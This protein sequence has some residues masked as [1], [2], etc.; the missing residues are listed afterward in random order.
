LIGDRVAGETDLKC[1]VETARGVRG[2]VS[3]SRKDGISMRRAGSLF[4]AA[5]GWISGI[6]AFQCHAQAAPR[7]TSPY[8]AN[9]APCHGT[10]LN[11]GP[12][13]PALKGEPFGSRWGSRPRT[14]LLEFMSTKMPPS[15]AGSLTHEE[16][17]DIGRQIALANGWPDP[18]AET[19]LALNSISAAEHVKA[20]E[21]RHLGVIP[22]N[23]AVFKDATYERAMLARKRL[24]DGLRPVTDEMLRSPPEEDWLAW[25]RTQDNSSFSPLAQIDRRNVSTLSIAWAWSMPVGMNETA[26]LVHDGVIFITSSN[27]VQALDATDGTLLWEYARELAP[28]FS[29]AFN[30]LQRNFA[31]YEEFVYVSTADRHVVALE[32]KS[33]RVIWDREIVPA[34]VPGVFLSSGPFVAHRTILQGTSNG[35]ACRGGCFVVG[36]NALTGQELWRFHTIAQPGTPGG[37]TW[38]NAGADERFGGAVWVPGAYDATRNLVYIGIAQTYDIATLLAPRNGKALGSNHALY[39]DSTVA[40]NPDTGRLVWYHQHLPRDVWDLDEAF[41]R[42]LITLAIDGRQRQIVVS[43]GKLG[44]M[45]GLDRLD[46]RHVFSMDLGLNNIVTH[47]DARTGDR[48]INPALVPK[49]NEQIGV[50]PSAEGARN[51]MSVAYNP[52]TRVMFLPLE[53][54]CMDFRWQPDPHAAPEQRGFDIGW[55][56]KPAPNADGNFARLQAVDMTTRSTQWIQRSRAPLSSSLLAT[57]GGV[58]FSGSRDR[59]F[60]ASDDRTG[61]TLWQTR[62]NAV[63]N[64]SPVT[65]GVSGT[66]FVAI[67][68]GGG[69]PHDAETASVTPEIVDSSASTTLWVFRLPH[70][71][72]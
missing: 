56:L 37:D 58:L 42:S 25:R 29:S 60:R 45:D 68:A 66:Q 32:A 23:P 6:C 7:E 44:I 43:T 49:P 18:A 71:A 70:L 15:N 67:A 22:P 50:C 64:A 19:K 54:N 4:V 1:G 36:L 33:G 34:G 55:S 46:G 72:E 14:D 12:F 61:E 41:E 39:T 40:L 65:Y 31:L 17:A 3:D 27:R 53:E 26:P 8:S 30:T 51:W 21:A 2:P 69:G 11:G 13:G 52:D 63:P 48:V 57:R 59:T 35:T 28:Q 10:E 9:C 20:A 62:L 24:L 5:A 38:N 47:I 16:Y